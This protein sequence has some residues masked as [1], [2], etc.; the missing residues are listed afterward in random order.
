MKPLSPEDLRRGW[1]ECPCGREATIFPAGMVTVTSVA[2]CEECGLIGYEESD[3]E[4]EN[5]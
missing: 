5:L 4:K 3:G 1:L 2:L